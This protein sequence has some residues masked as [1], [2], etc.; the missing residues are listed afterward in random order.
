MRKKHTSHLDWSFFNHLK[1]TIYINDIALLATTIND[2]R[3]LS[4]TTFQNNS[5]SVEKYN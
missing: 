2:L 5:L 3:A 4:N 1:N